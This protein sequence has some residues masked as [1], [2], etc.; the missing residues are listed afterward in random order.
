[1]VLLALSSNDY[2]LASSLV[3]N[4]FNFPKADAIQL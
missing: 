3:M 2:A 4:Q 1:V